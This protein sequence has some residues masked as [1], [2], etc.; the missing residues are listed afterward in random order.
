MQL[1]KEQILYFQ[2]NGFLLV[3]DVFDQAEINALTDEMNKI[4]A[5]DDP[6]RILEK[7]GSV[8]TFFAPHFTN[9][10]YDKVHR[11][12][13]LVV[14]ATQL[15]G[16]EVYLHQS[17]INIKEAMVGD[18][19]EWH[20]DYPYWKND[21][22]MPRPD[23]LTAMIFYNDVNEFNSPL[24]L[25]PSSHKEGIFDDSENEVDVNEQGSE[26][27]AEYLK[28]AS[29]M[30]SVTANLK[31]KLTKETIA[32]W[33]NRKGLFSAKGKAGAVLFFHG[34]VFHASS[35]NLSPWDRF[36]YLLTY[37]R[38]DNKL[39]DIPNPRPEF[40]SIRN[41]HPIAPIRERLA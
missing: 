16:N 28:S 39:M 36:T 27:Y 33:V 34:N 35:N 3:E 15:L 12:D 7:N 24:I 29:F 4:I 14:P 8:R 38:V 9:E 6:R 5:G 26:W 22:G 17:K 2:E 13:R 31:Y 40:I 1:T 41:F 30:T 19:W 25:I 32:A 18:W 20:Q 10:L 37:N 11:L 23:V 21:D